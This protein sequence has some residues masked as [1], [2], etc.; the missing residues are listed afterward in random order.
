MLV[1]VVVLLLVG[2]LVVGRCS[3]LGC[4]LW[5]AE[6]RAVCRWSRRWWP[7]PDKQ[8]AVSGRLRRIPN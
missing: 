2:W 5:V 4:R 6:R 1:M 7:S 3:T 8:S